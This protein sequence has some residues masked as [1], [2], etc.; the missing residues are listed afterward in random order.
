MILARLYLRLRLQHQR[1][2]L[3]DYFI[4]LA[5]LSAISQAAIDIEFK[6]LGLLDSSSK[7]SRFE[8]TTGNPYVTQTVRMNQQ[9]SNYR[10]IFQQ[11][12]FVSWF[13]LFT[14]QYLNKAALLSFYFYIFPS[15]L[16]PLLYSL[17]IATVYCGL[18]YMATI[19]LLF[20]ICLP[21]ETKG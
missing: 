11:M 1:L 5:W 8:S 17:W 13:P 2:I 6:K 20:L 3:S 16:R 19:L 10:L 12:V 21:V 9:L 14:T 18:A 4:C 15:N 7:W